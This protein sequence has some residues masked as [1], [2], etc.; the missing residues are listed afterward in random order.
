VTSTVFAYQAIDGSGRRLKGVETAA[1][2][3]A[4]TQTLESRGLLVLDIAPGE[5]TAKQAFGGMGQFSRR[6]DVLEVTRALAALLPAGLPLARALAAASDIAP[7]SVA[8]ALDTVRAK[9]ERGERLPTALEEHPVL[10]TPLYVGLVRA[11]ER[12]GDLAGAFSRLAYQ[13]E[14]EDE[15][16]GKLLSASIYPLVLAAAGGVAVVVLLT[17]VIPRFVEL[18][19]GTG[20]TLPRST[21]A[22]L[23]VSAAA[24]RFWPLWLALPAA[25]V[26]GIAWA[27]TT[28]EGRRA[29]AA[30]LLKLPAVGALRRNALG[31]RFARLVGVLLAGG[32][33]LLSALDDT[34]ECLGDPVAKDEIARIRARVR[35]GAALH[36]AIGEGTLFPPLLTQ[37]VAVG[38]GA[39]RI[40]EFLLKAA[41]ILEHRTARAVERLVALA[42]PAMIVVFGGLVGFVALSLLQAIYSVN[43]GALR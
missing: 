2:Q 1:N 41:E 13:L 42:E 8:Q 5:G 43:A 17:A 29:G 23:G 37:L 30:L 9:V 33:P 12:G 34:L 3:G 7:G 39:S 25:L 40:Q 36:A 38:E 11:G 32:A 19:E 18:L 28:E 14:R 24:R 27:R 35:E 31:A 21:A 10:F 16:R 4:L 20:A 6:R 26:L 15:L 22:L